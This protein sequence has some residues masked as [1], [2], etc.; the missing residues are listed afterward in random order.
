MV[1]ETTFYETLGVRF[2]DGMSVISQSKDHQV[3][4]E[5][6]EAE[7]RSAYKRGA[8]KHHPGISPPKTFQS[9]LR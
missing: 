9:V 1:K 4:P 8:L 2:P 6:T 5:A 7:L 3:S